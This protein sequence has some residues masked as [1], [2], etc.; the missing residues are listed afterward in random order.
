MHIDLVRYKT[1]SDEYVSLSS[2][3]LQMIP[4][5]YYAVR[6]TPAIIYT[7]LLPLRMG[8]FLL[9]VCLGSHISASSHDT[10]VQGISEPAHQMKKILQIPN[11]PN[12]SGSGSL[13]ANNRCTSPSEGRRRRVLREQVVPSEEVRADS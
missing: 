7:C 5:E 12:G 2:K 9:A 1:L 13:E 4:C 10:S 3:D 6:P 11:S 8:N